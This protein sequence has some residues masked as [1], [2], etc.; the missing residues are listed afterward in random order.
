MIDITGPPGCDPPNWSTS[1]PADITSVNAIKFELGSTILNP[2]DSLIIDWPMRTPV[3]VFS[4][5]GAQP[6]SISWN[7]FCLLYTS[8]SPRD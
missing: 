4:T 5:I 8:P 7:S 1:V 2:N 6:D 3:N